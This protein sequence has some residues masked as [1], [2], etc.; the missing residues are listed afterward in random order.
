MSD[1]VPQAAPAAWPA[2]F[3]LFLSV[4]VFGPGPAHANPDVY[5]A[6]PSDARVIQHGL[7]DLAGD[8]QKEL[9]VFFTAGE[10]ARL[11]LFFAR[12]GRWILLLEGPAPGLVLESGT[13]RC[14]EIMDANSDGR[15]EILTHSLSSRDHSM[16]TRI[17][18]LDASDGVSPSIRVL[19]EDVTS[20]PGYPL[21]GTE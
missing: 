18:T 17:L 1:Q 5:A 14:M 8:P 4:F 16:I 15:D 9:A 11:A 10:E 7:G 6:L 12:A 2:A 19:L 3:F 20:P 21:F 13:P